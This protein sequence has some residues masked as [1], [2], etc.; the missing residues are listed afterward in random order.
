MYIFVSIKYVEPCCIEF[1]ASANGS[2]N[3]SEG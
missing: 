2:M 1:D 3:K